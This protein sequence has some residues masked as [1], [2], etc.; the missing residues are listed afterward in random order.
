MSHVDIHKNPA[1]GMGPSPEDV[2]G[3]ADTGGVVGLMMV[4]HGHGNSPDPVE[5]L[6]HAVDYLLQHGGE[7]VVA[8]GSDFDG[9][10][11]TPK[12]LAS[13]RDFGA[14]RR[15]LLAHY[16]EEQTAKFLFGNGDRLLRMG[17]GKQ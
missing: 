14:V 2:R 10:A 15:A 6:L 13:P 12:E 4:H 1:E 17:W 16:T 9:Y 7:N 11:E 3:I 5:A 8:I